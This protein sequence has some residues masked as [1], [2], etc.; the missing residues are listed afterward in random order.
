MTWLPPIDTVVFKL[1]AIV[2]ATRHG[3]YHFQHT[4]LLRPLF[5]PAHNLRTAIGYRDGRKRL[6]ALTE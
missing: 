3:R 4:P 1:H 2:M 6:R 5:D